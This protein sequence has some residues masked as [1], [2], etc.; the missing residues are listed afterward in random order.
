MKKHLLYIFALLLLAF[1]CSEEEAVVPDDEAVYKNGMKEKIITF[2]QSSGT[3]EVIPCSD[4]PT[5][6]QFYISGT[7]IATH[8][9]NFTVVNTVCF[10]PVTGE[11]SGDWLGFITAANGDQLHTQMVYGPYF[12]EGPE[13]PTYY[14]YDVQEG[15]GRFEDVTGGNF[16]TY[17]YADWD[18]MTWTLQGGGPIYFE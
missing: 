7:G 10:D 17:G 9:G 16:I 14:D 4:C 15:T 11:F 12:P 13:G 6:F 18:N 2:K 8:L 3:M 5:G 1:G